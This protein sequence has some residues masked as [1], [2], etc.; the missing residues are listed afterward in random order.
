MSPIRRH[1]SRPHVE[2]L[3]IDKAAFLAGEQDIDWRQLN[4]QCQ[5]RRRRTNARASGA[6]TRMIIAHPA[7][8]MAIEVT[9][10]AIL[11]AT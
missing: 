1:P 10:I 6:P 11:R 3:A 8:T 7:I 2:V 4:N 9:P 5:C